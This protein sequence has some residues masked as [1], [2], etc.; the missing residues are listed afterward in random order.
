MLKKSRTNILI[1]HK[2]GES[3]FIDINT[4]IETLSLL[5]T[6]NVSIRD[7]NHTISRSCSLSAVSHIN[8]SA[9]NNAIISNFTRLIKP[10]YE[11]N[12][13]NSKISNNDSNSND[14][15][16]DEN[17]NGSIMIRIIKLITTAF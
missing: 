13:S 9:N 16:Q 7:G 5:L 4:I 11:R 17:V 14:N 6:P 10:I 3:A 2:S 1:G 12:N 15:N 8:S